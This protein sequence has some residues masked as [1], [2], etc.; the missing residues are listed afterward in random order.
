MISRSRQCHLYAGGRTTRERGGNRAYL[1]ACLLIL[2]WRAPC[3]LSTLVMMYWQEDWKKYQISEE[4]KRKRT[5]FRFNLWQARLKK[6]LIS[7]LRCDYSNQGHPTK[8]STNLTNKNWEV[9]NRFQQF[10]LV[11]KLYITKAIELWSFWIICWKI[12]V[13][14]HDI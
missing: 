7:I 4:T 2:V 8:F 3:Y 13:N 11:I 14:L 10:I 6:Y 5:I 9:N 1:Y 12:I